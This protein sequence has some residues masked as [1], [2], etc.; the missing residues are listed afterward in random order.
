MPS[1][2]GS[3]YAAL[4]NTEAWRKYAAGMSA[5]WERAEKR[6]MTPVREFQQKEL[7]GPAAR[8]GFVFY[9]F[10][11]PDVIY[12][13]GFYPNGNVYV[14]AGLERPGSIQPPSGFQEE[15]LEAQLDGVRQGSASLFERSF[16][17]TA[18]M[19]RQLRGQL[20]DG[21]LPVILM[22]LAR[23]GNTIE[24]VR[25]VGIDD[26]GKLIEL[27]QAQPKMGPQPDGLEIRYHKDGE[28]ESRKLYYFRLDL[29]PGLDK[30]PSFLTFLSQFG[31]PDTLIKSASFLL[32]NA[33]FARLR[34]YIVDHSRQI[35]QDDTG[36]RYGI[37][38]KHGWKVRLYGDYTRPDPPFR[39]MFQPDLRAAFDEPGAARE[40]GFSVGYGIG[41][42]ASHLVVAERP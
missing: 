5:A 26:A 36:V 19:S 28:R 10:S 15:N 42:R 4:E 22:L 34:G 13:Q 2:P 40:M 11:G 30:N 18:Q 35:V 29:G 23:T 20:V 41:R 17:I 6:R 9:P 32:H 37:F 25:N 21:V 33:A 1:T 12:M 38:R 3:G 16:F 39:G 8:R 14:L 27:A 7:G 31:Q 24:N